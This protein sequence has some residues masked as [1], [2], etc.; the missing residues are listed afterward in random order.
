MPITTVFVDVGGVLLNDGWDHIAR[1]RAAEHFHLEWA[2]MEDRHRL[3]CEIHEE[4]KL[5]FE[6]YSGRVVFCQKLL[7]SSHGL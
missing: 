4:G 6:E 5:T 3:N 1:G 2:E 7:D